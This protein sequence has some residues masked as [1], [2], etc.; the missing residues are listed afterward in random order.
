MKGSNKEHAKYNYVG[1]YVRC[2]ECQTEFFL[3]GDA[4]DTN[5]CSKV[6][7]KSFSKKRVIPFL[8]KQKA[9][10]DIPQREIK[11]C[12]KCGNKYLNTTKY[13][14]NCYLCILKVRSITHQNITYAS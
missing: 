13:L 6:C 10:Y 7:Q 5:F 3:K 11:M 2:R 9:Y 12:K 4:R 14:G 8:L 1:G